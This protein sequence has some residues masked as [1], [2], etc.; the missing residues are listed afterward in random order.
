MR[1]S[2]A[3]GRQGSVASPARGAAVCARGGQTWGCGRRR[4][5]RAG[6][7]ALPHRW[8]GQTQPAAACP[9][10]RRE[11][12][13]HGAKQPLPGPVQGRPAPRGVCG[14][15]SCRCGSAHLGPHPHCGACPWDTARAPRAP[16]TQ[17]DCVHT[18]WLLHVAS[19]V[20]T[21]LR[22]HSTTAST[23]W[24]SVHTS[25]TRQQCPA[26]PSP[27]P[28][29]EAPAAA[30]LAEAP[31]PN[32]PLPPVRSPVS[33][34]SRLM[35]GLEGTRRSPSHASHDGSQLYPSGSR[36]GRNQVLL[37]HTGPR[38]E[39]WAGPSWALGSPAPI[40]LGRKGCSLFHFA[41]SPH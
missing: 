39:G 16:S 4:G 33:V 14:V 40:C 25:S 5:G 8:R 7:P 35:L 19:P 22:L 41:L 11:R 26:W 23:R 24:G 38:R 37:D 20:H 2:G 13:Q 27:L 18:A 10:P 17:H 15:D 28:A 9:P 21:G 31:T 12:V 34:R 30:A 3:G 1:D 36:G 32:P 29:L 6:A